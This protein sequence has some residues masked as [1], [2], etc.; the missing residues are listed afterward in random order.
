MIAVISHDPGGAE[1]VSSH[2][3]RRNQQYL[4]A[5]GAVARKIF[6]RKLGPIENL[7]PSEAVGRSDSVL[8]GTSWQSDI[9]LKAIRQARSQGKKSIAFLD[10]WVNYRERFA[11]SGE[12][13]LPDE[14]WVGD[15]MAE[16]LAREC[17]PD[18]HIKLVPNPYLEDIRQ[19]L[20][21][22]PVRHTEETA[23]LSVLYVCEPIGEHALL[24]YGDRR[25]WGYTEDE[26]LR[27]FLANLA[28]LGKPVQR[29]TVR[30]HPSES[31]AK[32]DWLLAEYDLPIYFGGADGLLQE[33]SAA[34]CVAGCESMALVIALIAGKQ[35]FSC[36]PPGGRD[37]VLPFDEIT[38]LRDL[39]G[40]PALASN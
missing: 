11:R 35:V 3:R 23:S 14:I 40:A 18:I 8:C 15:A 20:Q 34:D 2:I 24:R 30:P 12:L 17:F 38:S 4:F 36:I 32:Y 31:S 7:E 28:A 16:N 39:L 22:M 9:E 5:L 13:V 19:E 1:L 27:F 37:C 26:A 10:H 29:I 6:E 25:Y 21:A 33:I